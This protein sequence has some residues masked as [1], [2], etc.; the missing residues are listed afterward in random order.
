MIGLE[1]RWPIVHM[2]PSYIYI[3]HKIM[4]PGKKKDT[5]KSPAKA[6]PK[7]SA[8]KKAPTK[9]AAETAQKESIEGQKPP[10]NEAFLRHPTTG[11]PISEYDAK[12]FTIDGHLFYKGSWKPIDKVPEKMHCKLLL[13]NVCEEPVPGDVKCTI[14]PK[15]TFDEGYLAAGE[16]WDYVYSDDE[17]A[18][19]WGRSN[20]DLRNGVLCADHLDAF[21]NA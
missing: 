17:E 16:E 10:A 14:N 3:L 21:Y 9:K 20:S 2:L 13:C 12:H 11:E 15:E 6:E 8:T 5:K 1:S 18:E 4:A 19:S 7:K